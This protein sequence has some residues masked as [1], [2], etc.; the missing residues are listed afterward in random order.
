[1]HT[2]KPSIVFE[3]TGVLAEVKFAVAYFESY[4]SELNLAQI[5][6]RAASIFARWSSRIRIVWIVWIVS[7]GKR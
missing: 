1:M 7:I 5:L 2:G 4:L 6:V 3:K